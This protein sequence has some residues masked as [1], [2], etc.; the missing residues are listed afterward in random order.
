M[1]HKKLE[2]RS[3]EGDASSYDSYSAEYESE[4]EALD[5]QAALEQQ[6]KLAAQQQQEWDKP[7]EKP[8][9]YAYFTVDHTFRPEQLFSKG[10]LLDDGSITL[11]V[12][13]GDI[14]LG[15]HSNKADF[16]RTQAAGRNRDISKFVEVRDMTSSWTRSLDFACPTIPAYRQEGYPGDGSCVCESLVPNELSMHKKHSFELVKR[17]V[18]E[19]SLLFQQRFPQVD[20]DTFHKEIHY[21]K[22]YAVL[23]RNH[24]TTLYYNSDPANADK[25]LDKPSLGYEEHDE[26][27]MPLD[28]CEKYTNM[29]REK[30]QN[31]ISFADISG[32]F[33]VKLSVPAPPER[34]KLHQR[35]LKT[36]GKEG[37]QWLGFAD[38]EYALAGHDPLALSADGVR[39]NAEAFMKTPIHFAFKIRADYLHTASVSE[40]TKS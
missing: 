6:K 7:T 12:K 20:P 17:E 29:A 37:K 38:A 2:T 35:W 33:V 39:T 31:R 16:T 19:G 14:K 28:A 34:L 10:K 15:R 5:T 40:Q 18:T 8:F 26:V 24:P 21:T 9:D 13:K 25:L 36:D 23:P 30:M 11:S 1:S 4:G 22:N 32:N 27:R 3:D